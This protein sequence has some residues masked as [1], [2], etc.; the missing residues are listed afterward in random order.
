VADRLPAA[1]SSD[2]Q[3]VRLPAVEAI[4]GRGA[5]TPARP[6]PGMLGL[7]AL[8]PA[9]AHLV[10]A[11]AM[12]GTCRGA[13]AVA[14]WRGAGSSIALG[15]LRPDDYASPLPCQSASLQRDD[16]RV[17]LQR[18]R[19]RAAKRFA[20]NAKPVHRRTLHAR[21]LTA[22]VQRKGGAPQTLSGVLSPRMNAHGKIEDW[23]F[24]W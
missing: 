18:A 20:Q 14:V 12:P 8:R 1:E 5:R 11:A 15:E 13:D 16:R 10:G 23:D 22:T 19:S 7:P 4:R 17:D 2:L 6:P 3:I 9:R 24:H 21:S